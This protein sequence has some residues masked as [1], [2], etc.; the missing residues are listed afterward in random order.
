MG[1]FSL[2]DDDTE[3]DLSGFQPNP[4]PRHESPAQVRAIEAV[5]KESGFVS[6]QPTPRRK[7]PYID[8]FNVKVRLGAKELFQE[9]AARLDLRDNAAMERALEA[10]FEKEGLTDL[11]SELNRLKAIK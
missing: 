5:A 2:D 3:L 6:R 11:L 8:Q 10:F 7:S 9:A 4:T 1:K